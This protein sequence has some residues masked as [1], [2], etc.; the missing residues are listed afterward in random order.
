[1]YESTGKLPGN[2]DSWIRPSPRDGLWTLQLSGLYDQ[3]LS[4]QSERI[5]GQYCTV[6]L[7]LEPVP[8]ELLLD[9]HNSS[10]PELK[11]PVEKSLETPRHY[12]DF[13]SLKD[14]VVSFCLPASC[15]VS[16][17]RSAVAQRFG[18]YA[19]G[20]GRNLSVVTAADA[21]FCSTRASVATD[22]A[23]D[24]GAIAFL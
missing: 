8:A 16:D 23:L 12:Y 1:M 2:P 13:A 6:F 20:P 7:N 5:A 22:S 14:V 17:L 19:V 11:N 21:N 10:S 3:C 18:R 9:G 15:N 4:I 24:G